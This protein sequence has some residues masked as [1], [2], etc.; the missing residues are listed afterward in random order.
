MRIAVIGDLHYPSLKDTYAFIQKDRQAFYDTFIERFF[1]VPADLYVSIGDLTNYGLPDELEDIYSY[2]RRHEKPFVHVLGNHDI[3]GLARDEVL[4]ITKQERFHVMPTESAVLV[5]IDTAKEQDFDDWG[6]TLD[7]TQL[8]WL[9]SVMEQSGN[10]PLILFA[11]HPVHGT[12][13]N[14]EKEKLCIHPDVPIWELL[15]KKQGL[16]LY[17]NGHNHFNSI[18]ERDHWNFLQLAAVLDEQAVRVIEVADSHISINSVDLSDAQLKQQAQVIGEAIDH[19]RLN[20]F[21]SG[22]GANANQVIS[23]S[24]PIPAK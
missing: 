14:F 11:H 17:V 2:I 5:F 3:Y 12:T 4:A 16:G 15:S 9:E 13:T 24:P 19:F 8:E 1:S 21:S 20:P 7:L 18:A 23:L 22:T 6:G 10:L